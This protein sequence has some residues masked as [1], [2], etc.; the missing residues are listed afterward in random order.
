MRFEVGAGSAERLSFTIGPE[1][2]SGSSPI[3]WLYEGDIILHTDDARQ[4]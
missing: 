3:A 2:Y 1:K 4:P